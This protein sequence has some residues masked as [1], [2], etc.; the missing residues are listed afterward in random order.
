MGKKMAILCF[1]VAIGVAVIGCDPPPTC[2]T[3]LKHITSIFNTAQNPFYQAIGGSPALH[4]NSANYIS[5]MY[6]ATTANLNVA[7]YDWSTPIYYTT[8]AQSRNTYIKGLV[9]H[10]KTQAGPIRWRTCIT[11]SPMGD[12]HAIVVDEA[13]QCIY[14]LWGVNKNI[15]V[16]DPDAYWVSGLP[17]SDPDGLYNNPHTAGAG[18]AM[19]VCRYQGIVWPDEVTSTI[20]HGFWACWINEHNNPNGGW[21]VQPAAHAD[22]VGTCQYDSTNGM[23]FQ[24]NPSYDISGW[25]SYQQPIGQALKD[26]GYYQGNSGGSWALNAASRQGYTNNPWTGI[27][28]DPNANSFV[29]P[30]TINNFRLLAIPG[31]FTSPAVALSS[32]C[33]TYSPSTGTLPVITSI[34]PN[35]GSEAGGTSVTLTG[36]GFN[37]VTSV[38]FYGGGSGTNFNRVSDTQIICTTPAK[39][40]WNEIVVRASGAAGVNSNGV[41]FTYGVAPSTPSLSAINPTSGTTA[42]GTACTLTGANLTGCS[43]VSF[44]GTAATGISVVSS[45]QVR[46]TSPAKSA[47]TI[48]V[49]ATTSNGTSN[50]VNYTYN[51]PAGPTLSAINPT[52]GTTAGG[53]VCT[54]TGTNL[55]GTTGV[56]FG[57]TAGTSIVNVSS[58][59]VRAT[60][61]AKTAGT[62]GVTAT[63]ANGTSN[64]VSYTYSGG[65]GSY[66]ATLYT[67]ADAR[68]LS[69]QGGTNYGTIITLY[70]QK[71]AAVENASYIKW[72]LNS[73]QGATITSAKLRLYRSGTGAATT[74]KVDSCATDTWTETGITWNNKPAWGTQQASFAVAAGGSWNEVDV[75]SYVSANFNGD[76][77]VTMVIRDD[78]NLNVQV[79]Y[80]S[81]ENGS[82]KP[83]LVVIR[84]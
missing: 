30:I 82:N 58:T 28:A 36:T 26:Y 12:G 8:S 45:T 67:P 7:M 52:S 38:S 19:G 42:G 5:H 81:D 20:P 78:Q 84:S 68:V 22:G 17:W 2:D 73:V 80:N 57:G 33:L 76:K 41:K 16:A 29:V 48:S 79:P 23:H 14:D 54:L 59:Q 56:S 70:V 6:S 71:N 13:D 34:S 64:A 63:T 50:G 25:N 40:T 49:T 65:G 15:G 10:G 43:A 77:L 60:S 55:T 24:L 69:S 53:T 21:C 46:C 61:P 62:Y 27:L 37:A 47:G 66:T 72:D 83:Q 18:A 39:T 35:S 11:G 1:V 4:P 74:N 44:G 31:Y 32:S 51:A 3:N 75:T 9:Y